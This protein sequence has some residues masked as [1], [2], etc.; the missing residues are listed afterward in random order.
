MKVSHRI[1]ARKI[2]LGYFYQY[3]F[4]DKLKNNDIVLKEILALDFVFNQQEDYVAKKEIFSKEILSYCDSDSQEELVYMIKH[5]FD[6]WKEDT[7]DMDYLFKMW[8]NM[9][10]YIDEM[11]L[12]VD[13]YAIS[14]PYDQMDTID[15]AIFLLWY[16]ERK[17][18]ETPKEILLNELVE[19]AKRYADEWSGKLINGI[20]HKIISK[21]QQS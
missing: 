7:I 3:L 1:H 13:S 5:F 4:F 18:L 9:I 10:K 21:K 20:M 6:L 12:A 15:Q 8:T 14:F 19:M 11:I 16:V 2:V 17:E